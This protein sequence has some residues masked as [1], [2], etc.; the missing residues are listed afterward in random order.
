MGARP[1]RDRIV[2]VGTHQHTVIHA[3]LAKFCEIGRLAFGLL[4]RMLGHANL[5][6]FLSHCFLRRAHFA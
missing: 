1:D 4:E 6:T 5:F 3:D 2:I